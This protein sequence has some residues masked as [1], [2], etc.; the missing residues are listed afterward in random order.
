MNLEEKPVLQEASDVDEL[1]PEQ[2]AFQSL[3]ESLK[4]RAKALKKLATE[5]DKRF[6]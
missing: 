1:S 6:K 4:E 3:N 5:L 2:D